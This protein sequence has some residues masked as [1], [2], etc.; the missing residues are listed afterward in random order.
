LAVVRYLV[1]ELGADVN[2]AIGNGTTTLYIAAC[3]GHL[4]M[5]RCLVKEPGA[6]VNKSMHGATPLMVAASHNHEGVVA[7]LIKYG[8][9]TQSCTH[10]FDTA[11][12]ISRAHAGPSEQVQYLEVRTHCANTGCDG[13]GIKKCAGCLK[14]CY[15]ARECQVAHWSAHK[16]VCQRSAERVMGKSNSS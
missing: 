11:A 9:N 10:A 6:E 2:Q 8:A 4:A 7:F 12:E 13:A 14:V 1:K 3:N 16:T 15:C 5:V